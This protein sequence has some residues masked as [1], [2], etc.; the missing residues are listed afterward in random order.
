VPLNVGQF[1]YILNPYR[2]FISTFRTNKN[3]V[4]EDPVALYSKS[5]NDAAIGF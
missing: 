2:E 4:A 3:A 1:S 5:I